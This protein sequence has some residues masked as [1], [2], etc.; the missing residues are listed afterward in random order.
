MVTEIW[1]PNHV[2]RGGGNK[3]VQALETTFTSVREYSGLN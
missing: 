2:N 1:K 3:S